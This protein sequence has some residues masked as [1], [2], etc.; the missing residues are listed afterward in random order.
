M[1]KKIHHINFVVRNLEDA[2]ERYEKLFQVRFTHRE[3]LPDRAVETARFRLGDTWIVLVQP[4]SA[5]G[6]VGRF[7]EDNGEGFLLISYQVDDV[8]DS[9]K[10]IRKHGGRLL[11]ATPRA[12][13][14]GWQLIDVDPQAI[15]GVATQIVETRN[16]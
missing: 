6:T 3:S 7:L 12:G 8:I 9:A 14:E 11:N 13:L 1:L 4:T 16:E 15:C 5:D 2:I 10:R